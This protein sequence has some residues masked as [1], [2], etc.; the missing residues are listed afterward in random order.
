MTNVDAAAV[1][2][3]DAWEILVG[4]FREPGDPLPEP[5]ASVIG[6]WDIP[7]L[8][9][10]PYV[11]VN[12]MLSRDGRA[13]F[14]EPDIVSPGLLALGKGHDPWLMGV[15]RARADAVMVGDGTLRANPDHL[16]TPEYIY[17]AAT[18][19]FAELRSAENL[20]ERTPLVLVSFDAD[21]P[22]S[23]AQFRHPDAHTILATTAR[24]EQQARA[25]A[26]EAAGRVD[27]EVVGEDSVDLRD[28]L[29]RLRQTYGISRLLC[30]GGPRLYAGLLAE[31]LVDDEFLTLSPIVMGAAP[32]TSRPSLVEGIAFRPENA[33]VSRLLS[34]ARSGDFL[35]LRSRYSD[36][37]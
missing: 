26:E 9:D 5:W 22:S 11:Y 31:G 37:G 25:L 18:S 29:Y 15:L 30:E 20:A 21:L 6:P 19:S 1:G 34:V 32:A 33:P 17:P 14:N 23:A 12:F 8:A 4:D 2:L 36:I 24:G 7:H 35:F 27:V 28:L 3:D 10:R 13:T 16:W